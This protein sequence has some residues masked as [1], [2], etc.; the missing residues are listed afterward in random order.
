M[1]RLYRR[2]QHHTQAK[3]QEGIDPAMMDPEKLITQ[4][5]Y[6]FK[7]GNAHRGLGFINHGI[8]AIVDIDPLLFYSPSGDLPTLG[9]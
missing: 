7:C 8:A 4:G 2:K 6:E 3:R 9:T 1:R 5:N